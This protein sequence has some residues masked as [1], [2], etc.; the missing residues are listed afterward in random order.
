MASDSEDDDPP[1]S[2]LSSLEHASAH[3]DDARL[4][5]SISTVWE[6]PLIELVTVPPS[7]GQLNSTMFWKCL[8]PGC[9]KKFNGKNATKALAHGSR[10]TPC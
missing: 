10:E 6:H 5:E 8:A 7:E 4:P 3:E 9:Q 2:P 1:A